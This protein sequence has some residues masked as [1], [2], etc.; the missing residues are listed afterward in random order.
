MNE[1]ITFNF[2]DMPVRIVMNENEPQFVAADV[3]SIL[4]Y[5]SA[6]DLARMLDDDEKGRHLVPTLGGE[7]EMITI[8]EP[9]LYKAIMRS[10]KPEAKPFQ[11]VVTHDILPSIRK[12]GSYTA[13]R[14]PKSVN[15]LKMVTSAVR[16]LPPFVKAA[17]LLGCD[18][19]AAV[20]SATQAVRNLTN[21]DVMEVLGQ[22]HLIAANQEE[23]YYTPTALGKP[24]SLSGQAFNKILVANGLQ[25]RVGEEWVPTELG[26]PYARIFDTMKRHSDGAAIPQVK[27]Q[28]SVIDILNLTEVKNGT[29]Q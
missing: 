3:A 21:I 11:R 10:K 1:L 15:Q 12:T 25:E 28:P 26:R 27:W 29:L 7:Q 5:A 14:A 4:E 9:G 19:N 6:K 24:Y 8:T 18:D 22:T 2:N 16:A 13:P 20:I 23:L 17:K